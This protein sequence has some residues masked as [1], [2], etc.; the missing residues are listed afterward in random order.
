MKKTMKTKIVLAL[1]MSGAVC[2]SG[3]YGAQAQDITINGNE[4]YNEVSLTGDGNTVTISNVTQEMMR[5]LPVLVLE[6]T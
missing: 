5:L 1:L 3:I 4:E 6:I 2:M